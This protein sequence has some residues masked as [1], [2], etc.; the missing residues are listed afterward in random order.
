MQ[1]QVLVDYELSVARQGYI[2]RA[3]VEDRG[4]GAGGHAARAPQPGVGHR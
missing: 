3:L 1:P 2:V 4:T